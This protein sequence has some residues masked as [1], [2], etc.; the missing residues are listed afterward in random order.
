MKLIGC[1]Q[2]HQ[3][4]CGP[5]FQRTHMLSHLLGLESPRRLEETGMP[6]KAQ[7]TSDISWWQPFPL[8]LLV[9]ECRSNV[10]LSLGA[11][12]CHISYQQLPWMPRDLSH[13]IRTFATSAYKTDWFLC[14]TDAHWH[15]GTG[16]WVVQ[17]LMSG[18]LAW[19]ARHQHLLRY[20][21]C[22]CY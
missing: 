14:G 20:Y 10:R 15:R 5:A 9:R 1:H 21:Y 8:P 11:D 4:F 7:S 3:I 22:Y 18:Y 19:I 16:H 13:S 6:W 2:T 17:I 12:D